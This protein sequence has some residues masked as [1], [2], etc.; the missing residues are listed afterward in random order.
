MRWL[1]PWRQR[2]GGGA[3]AAALQ[4]ACGLAR[5][6]TLLLSAPA[7]CA[8][9]PAQTRAHWPLSAGVGVT[10]A[11][12]EAAAADGA[13]GAHAARGKP[14][15]FGGGSGTY[16]FLKGEVRRGALN[17]VWIIELDGG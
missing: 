13:A 7:P 4:A 6:D 15:S 5:L 8:P 3:L 11:A 10:D 17:T 14:Q 16:K 9:L 2:A 1:L 12:E